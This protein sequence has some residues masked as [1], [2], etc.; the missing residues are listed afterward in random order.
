MNIQCF[1]KEEKMFSLECFLAE[2][3][4]S[5]F[6]INVRW[7]RKNGKRESFHHRDD[8]MWMKKTGEGDRWPRG[9]RGSVLSPPK[10]LGRGW[11]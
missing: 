8:R 1:W 5:L 9:G 6:W 3:E 2:A 11:R 10:C 4:M 7:P